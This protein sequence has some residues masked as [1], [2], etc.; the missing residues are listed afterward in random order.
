MKTVI[1]NIE[2]NGLDPKEIWCCTTIDVETGE[3]HAFRRPDIHQDDFLAYMRDVVCIVG[4]NALAYDWPVLSRLTRIREMGVQ[5]NVVDTLVVSR[6]LDFNRAGGHSL[7]SWSEVLA[8]K[9]TDQPPWEAY[10]EALVDHSMQNCRITLA[11][12]RRFLPY[13]NSKRWAS[14]IA[15][16]HFMVD[17]CREIHLNG[18]HFN[19][20][21]A[22]ELRYNINKELEELDREL[23]TAFPPRVKCVREVTPRFTKFGTLNRNDF[24]WAGPD[25]SAFTG[26]P[27]TLIEYEDFNPGSPAQIVERLNEAGWRPTEKTKGHLQAIRDKDQEKIARFK[28]TGWKITEANLNTLPPEAPAAAQLLAMRITKASRVRSLDEWIKHVHPDSRIRGQ[29]NHIGA[30]TMRCSHDKPNTANIPTPQPL[31]PKSTQT[32]IWANKIDKELRSLWDVEEG[33]LVGVDA[34]SIQLRVLAHYMDDNRF[35]RSLLSGKKEDKTDPHSLNKVALGSP[36]KSR[37]ASKVFIY[38]WLLGA[39][40]GKVAEILECNYAEA[41]KSVDDFIAFYPGLKL[42]KSNLIPRDAARGYFEG[43]DGRYINIFGDDQGSR[44]HFCLAGYLQ[45]GESIIMKRAASIWLPRLHKERLPFKW[46]G[47]IHD[48]YETQVYGD[49]DMAEYIAK[50]QM[51]SIRQA[52]EELNLR[53]PMA[54]SMSIGKDWSMSH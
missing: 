6:L 15:L 45:A 51:D 54:G 39:G 11:L 5:F 29:I 49:K 26:G 1:L 3:E 35:T 37:E 25:L 44:E 31:H 50:I 19:V 24:R 30:W 46:V 12:Y 27:F 42:L 23:S 28:T 20:D 53:C 22:K 34:E 17:A 40:V 10:S 7:A 13:I 2:A 38:A 47:Y 21:K 18:F 14:S 52:G 48:E 4:H 36:C 43:F 32:A 8:V 16:E 41:K 33:Y 9:K